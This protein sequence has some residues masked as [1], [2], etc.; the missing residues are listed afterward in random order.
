[1]TKIYCIVRDNFNKIINLDHVNEII[2]HRN[3]NISY[4][5]ENKIE[6]IFENGKSCTIHF[7]NFNDLMNEY[8]II[9]K[10]MQN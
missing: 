5:N 10:N 8:E 6:F 9:K 2:F 3:E 4:R 1:M 7:N